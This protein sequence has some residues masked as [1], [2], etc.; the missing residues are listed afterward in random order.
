MFWWFE[1]SEKRK[2]DNLYS[3]SVEIN[4]EILDLIEYLINAEWDS[5][6]LKQKIELGMKERDIIENEIYKVEGI[7]KWLQPLSL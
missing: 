6:K 3:E 7:P 1:L 5:N 2:I 4:H